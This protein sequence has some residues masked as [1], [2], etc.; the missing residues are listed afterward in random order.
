[1]AASA[2]YQRRYR[3][4]PARDVKEERLLGVIGNVPAAA[5]YYA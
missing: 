3:E 1:M 5:N 2:Y 4:H